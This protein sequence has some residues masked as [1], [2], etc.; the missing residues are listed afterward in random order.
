MAGQGGG[1]KRKPPAS[2]GKPKPGG[3]RPARPPG[4]APPPKAPAGD[5]ATAATPPTPP[6]EAPPRP[7]TKAQ[8]L[9][10][11]RQARRRKEK[12]RSRLY[13]GGAAI[14]VLA[15][16][17]YVVNDKL[18]ERRA[19]ER[20]DA[21]LTAGD[22]TVDERTDAGGEGTHIPNPTY[23]VNPPAGGAHT[24]EAASEGVY[25]PGEAPADGPLVHALEHGFIVIWYDPT[26]SAADLER[27]EDIAED[28]DYSNA[29]LLVP[30]EGMDVPV[31][32]TAWHERLLC[33]GVEEKP[34][35][36]FIK[37]RRDQ[38]PETGFIS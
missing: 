15:I 13:A 23:E 33:P 7:E 12:M 9:E 1:G 37:A 31:A 17:G 16:I 11:A 30:R 32:A 35:T 4:A 22:C 24:P 29:T 20:L 3:G 8:R 19:E 34:L 14:L 25:D 2:K 21:I 6:K 5:A 26:I 10:A 36:E 18:S 27:L 38:G 28:E